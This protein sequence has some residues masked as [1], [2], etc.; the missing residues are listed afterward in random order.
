[1]FDT[2]DR[3]SLN[4]TRMPLKVNVKCHLSHYVSTNVMRLC[5]YDQQSPFDQTIISSSL[6]SIN[7]LCTSNDRQD[8]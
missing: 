8:F 7:N 2:S 1:M 4:R 5:T 3:R 6:F